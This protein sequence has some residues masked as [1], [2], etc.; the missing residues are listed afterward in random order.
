MGGC[1]FLR[2]VT[3][4]LVPR[5][6]H[7]SNTKLPSGPSPIRKLPAPCKK[8]THRAPPGATNGGHLQLSPCSSKLAPGTQRDYRREFAQLPECLCDA[9]SPSLPSMAPAGGFGSGLIWRG[10][11]GGHAVKA[12]RRLP[13]N[14]RMDGG[15]ALEW[16]P[17]ITMD[18]AIT[19]INERSL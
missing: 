5:G 12:T 7:P 10:L 1:K 15:A 4:H 8:L 17:H 14:E 11:G 19:A 3:S 13:E 2:M 9:S 6:T 18:T 16:K